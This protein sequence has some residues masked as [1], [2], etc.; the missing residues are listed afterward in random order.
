MDH[1]RLHERCGEM[2]MFALGVLKEDLFGDDQAEWTVGEGD[3]ARMATRLAEH[4]EAYSSFPDSVRPLGE[5]WRDDVRLRLVSVI[6]DE[7]VETAD[8]SPREV[9]MTPKRPGG[10]RVRIEVRNTLSDDPLEH[11]YD[12][13]ED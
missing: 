9:V 5:M 4:I 12:E 6:T 3:K 13:E 2:V 11:F 1:E 10:V 7:P 8:L